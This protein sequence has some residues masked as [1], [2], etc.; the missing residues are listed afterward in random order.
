MAETSISTGGR[1]L[2]A[3]TEPASAR[4]TPRPPP[5]PAPSP[6]F[7][8]ASRIFFGIASVVLTVLFVTMAVAST[9]ASNNAAAAI[10]A[11]LTQTNARV[12]DI[13]AGQRTTMLKLAQQFAANPDFR[14]NV[15]SIGSATDTT[16]AYATAV[17]LAGQADTAIG[18]TWT[19]IADGHGMLIARSDRPEDR[20]TQL[21]GPLIDGALQGQL[22]QGFGV[23]DSIYLAQVVAV[24][25]TGAG[26]SIPG[27]LMSLR[28]IEDS[29][30]TRI[31]EQTGSEMIFYAVMANK[32][33]EI[34]VSSPNLGVRAALRSTIERGMMGAAANETQPTAGSAMMTAMGPP[35]EIEIAGTHYVGQRVAAL[36]AGGNEVGGFI[37]L[38]DKDKELAGFYKLRNALFA[39]GA[40][41]LLIAFLLSVLISRQ[42]VRPVQSLVAAT[43]RAIEGDYNADIPVASHDEIG[44]LAEA[45]KRMLADLRDKQALVDFLQSSSGGRTVPLHRITPTMQMR[46][47]QGTGVLEPGQTLAT[48]YEITTVLG[49]GGMGMVYKAN[50]R[51]LGEVVA[52]KTLKADLMRQDPTALDRF[53]SEIRLARKIAHRNVVRTYDLGESGGVYFITMEYVDGKSLKDLIESRGR[54]PAAVVLPIAKQLCRA[55]EAAHEEGVIHRDVKPQN[56]VVQSDGVLKVM[57]FVI[58][59][60]A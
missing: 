33:P 58:A 17:D 37:A 9:V 25:I 1:H 22:M 16:N 50:D 23:T 49:V 59:R 19:Q 42:I 41:G 24:P 5:R 40:G 14:A 3:Y 36:S 6:K 12:F 18:G 29:I 48:R 27:V 47:M 44:A 38:R 35:R 8:L 34:S 13:L 46:A 7:G 54:L 2:A 39:A 55:L 57:D 52:V 26:G 56:M 10:Q 51:E 45:F 4:P 31:G 21:G 28:K 15:Q 60:L 11:G 43:Q 20:G 30:A 53:K 32:Q